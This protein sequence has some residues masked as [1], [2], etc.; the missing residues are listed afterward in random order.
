MKISRN[1]LVGIRIGPNKTFNSAAL[2]SLARS[3]NRDID[4]RGSYI[5]KK[6]LGFR[7]M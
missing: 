3:Q 7:G 1:K 5:K 4:C 6:F 2:I